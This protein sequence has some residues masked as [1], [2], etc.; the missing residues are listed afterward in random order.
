M[1]DGRILITRCAADIPLHQRDL[2]PMKRWRVDT[3]R[4]VL[5]TEAIGYDYEIDL[6]VIDDK[7]LSRA[8][9]AALDWIQHVGGKT[10]ANSELIGEMALFVSRR[11]MERVWSSR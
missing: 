4:N 2:P 3:D 9:S 8:M 1:D 6:D 5:V 7:K 10:W 11:I